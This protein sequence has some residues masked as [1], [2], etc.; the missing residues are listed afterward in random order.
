M[1]TLS[2]TILTLSLILGGGCGKPKTV[3]PDTGSN[4]VGDYSESDRVGDDDLGLDEDSEG[5]EELT[6]DG[7]AVEVA[8]LPKLPAPGKPVNKCVNVKV[9]EG[10]KKKTEKKCGLVDPKP[11]V[12]A[13]YGARTLKGEFRWGMNT[14]DV[15]KLLS[16]EIEKEYT[17]K[18]KRRARTR[19]RKTTPAPG[20]PSSSR[21]SRRTTSASRRAPSTAGACR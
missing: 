13:S 11:E 8:E 10:K 6:D 19:W 21:S 17:D 7:T 2:C 20:E 4:L 1:R 14:K 5:G 15:F 9:G 12:S 3:D 18:Q 16:R